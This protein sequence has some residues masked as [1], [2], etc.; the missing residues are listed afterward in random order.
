MP[1]ASGTHCCQIALLHRWSRKGT[2][3]ERRQAPHRE[4][5][6]S[7]LCFLLAGPRVRTRCRRCVAAPGTSRPAPPLPT[8]PRHARQAAACGHWARG[9]SASR[10]RCALHVFHQWGVARSTLFGM[11]AQSACKHATL[12]HTRLPRPPRLQDEHMYFWFPLLAGLSELTFDPRPEIRCGPGRYWVFLLLHVDASW[13]EAACLHYPKRGLM[14]TTP[15]CPPAHN[16]AFAG[17]ARWRCCLTSSSST[18]PPS[19]PSSGCASSTRCCCPSS[20]TCG[21]R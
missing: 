5:Q 7:P 10:T 20:T 4:L 12:P 17:T 2:A 1:T 11:P 18:A 15:P 16:P 8:A 13:F 6:L 9:A 21:P 3:P 14:L 19:R